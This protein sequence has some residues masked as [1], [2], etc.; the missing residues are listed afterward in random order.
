M[1]ELVVFVPLLL[2]LIWRTGWDRGRRNGMATHILTIEGTQHA[3][4]VNREALHRIPRLD[5]KLRRDGWGE[6][7]YIYDRNQSVYT[8]H[9]WEH[10]N[11]AS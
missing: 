9:R 10:T 8:P 11:V 1:P 7:G 5:M 4:I 2:A 6:H 3:L